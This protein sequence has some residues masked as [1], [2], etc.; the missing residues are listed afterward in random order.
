MNR[1]TRTWFRIWKFTSVKPDFRKSRYYRSL[2]R[3][4]NPHAK[5]SRYQL[6]TSVTQYLCIWV[7][8]YQFS[9]FSVILVSKFPPGGHIGFCISGLCRWHGF[10]S[11]TR[12]CFGIL[13][14]NFMRT[15][16]VTVG[17]NLLIFSDVTF[18]MAFWWPYW[19]FLL[20]GLKFSLA[21][22]IKCKLE[23]HL[24]DLYG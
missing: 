22:N 21:L 14:S 2:D 6:Q 24:T 15:S 9:W 18:K 7:E 19:D 13:V 5:D 3:S 8:A 1:F 16:F 10:R 23:Q 4:A 20:P 17:R 12:V 11:I